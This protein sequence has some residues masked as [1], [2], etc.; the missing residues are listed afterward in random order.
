MGRNISCEYN[1][2]A[3]GSRVSRSSRVSS[4]S[5][6]CSSSS[7]S[8]VC[9][10]MSRIS[11]MWIS[12]VWI[13]RVRISSDMCI[14]I[15]ISSD[16]CIRYW[17]VA[18]WMTMSLVRVVACVMEWVSWRE[19]RRVVCSAYLWSSISCWAVVGG[20]MSTCVMPRV[21]RNRMRVLVVRV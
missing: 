12:W 7:A 4:I 3:R 19:V 2:S 15:V 18:F 17:G 6:V 9:W 10:V 8:W 13:T 14:R 5:R 20:D 1:K 21:S 11:R 16:M